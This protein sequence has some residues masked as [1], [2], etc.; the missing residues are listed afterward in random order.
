MSYFE[1]VIGN[2]FGGPR[3]HLIFFN[4]SLFKKY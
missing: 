1:V 4:I 2:P 3:L